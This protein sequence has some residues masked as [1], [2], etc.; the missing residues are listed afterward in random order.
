MNKF[1]EVPFYVRLAMILISVAIILFL[2][3]LGKSIFVPLFF[4]FLAAM[5]LYPVCIWLEKKL[6]K[7]G[8]AS[9]ISV[10][11][12]VIGIGLFITFFTTQIINFSKD[13]P[14]IQKKVQDLLTGLQHWVSEKYGIDSSEQ[15][16][17][18]YKGAAGILTT[19]ANSIGGLFV[20]LLTFVIWTI[21]M[22]IYTFFILYHRG[23]LIRFILALFKPG[24]RAKAYDVVE[25]TRTLINSYVAGLLT[26]MAIMAVL[27]TA[28][29]LIIGAHYAI[30]LGL[31]AAVLNI[32]PYLGIY[33]AMAI[34]MLLTFANGTPA[35]AL[36]VGIMLI[37]IHFVDAN[38]LLP[39]I[40]GGRVKMNP[41]ITIIA[42]LVGH[43]VWG[44]PGMF[45][46]IPLTAMLK[47]VFEHVDALKPWAILIGT[48]DKTPE[49][50][51]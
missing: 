21:F 32:I 19:A 1:F 30:L 50:G 51:K 31:L 18:V 14:L 5:L 13:I 38:F 24:H 17:Y 49:P 9:A 34:A 20:N 27:N 16:E 4:A 40:V 46:F 43:L 45:L 35:Q 15:M 23:L 47:V 36:E 42:V 41:F 6:M 44:I 11:L 39:R 26:E 29:F 10:L 7:R 12:F 8:L 28:G 3:D 33:T 37:A 2:L 22:L 25:T 48:E